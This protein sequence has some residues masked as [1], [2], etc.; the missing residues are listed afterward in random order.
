VSTFRHADHR[1]FFDGG[2]AVVRCEQ[3]HAKSAASSFTRT[4]T[5][6]ASCHA[7]VHL[8]QVGAKCEGCHAVAAAK[9]ALA[10]FSH[11]QTAFPLGG[12]HAPVP[13]ASCHKRETASFPSGAGTAVRLTGMGRA[14]VSCHQDPHGAQLGTSCEQCHSADTFQI[15]RYTHR[16]ARALSAFFAGAHQAARCE[17]C[18]T[19]AAAPAGVRAG[20]GAAAAVRYQLPTTCTSCHQDRHRGA[21][22]P[23]CETCHRLD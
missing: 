1:P 17:A 18:H 16:N 21:L 14:C 19:R 7:D 10:G 20:R 23:R 8:G 3:C 9:F 13:C 2:H 6:C 15:R 22:G 12:K 11:A 4:A 5:A